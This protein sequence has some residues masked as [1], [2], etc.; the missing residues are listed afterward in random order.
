MN[1]QIRDSLK[2]VFVAPVRLHWVQI[3]ALGLAAVSSYM[4]FMGSKDA[5]KAAKDA[6]QKEAAIAAEQYKIQKEGIAANQEEAKH[7]ASTDLHDTT[8]AFMR[9]RAA[10]TAG[11]G[12]A[13]VAGGS[14][15]RTII[16]K[17]RGEQDLRGRHM[18]ALEVF[19]DKA[20]RDLRSAALG[21][22]AA[23]TPYQGVSTSAL[24]IS[25]GLNFASSA[26]SIGTDKNGDWKGFS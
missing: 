5:E 23:N 25:A 17:T 4:G 9:Q 3:A 14:V 12:E 19:N 21:F 8:I 26:L 6:A 7:K 1:R 2:M 15:T 22:S 18:Y 16:D 13:G 10:V 24:A 11:A 20:G